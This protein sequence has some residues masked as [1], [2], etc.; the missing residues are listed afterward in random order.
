MSV[1]LLNQ[2]ANFISLCLI[3]LQSA[4]CCAALT[5]GTLSYKRHEFPSFIEQKMCVQILSISF[6][7]NRSDSEKNLASYYH[8]IKQIFMQNTRFLLRNHSHLNLY[9]DFG[10]L[11]I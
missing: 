3:I 7:R 10:S 9:T 4:A 1:A 2:Q 8:R 11:E 6:V 5:F